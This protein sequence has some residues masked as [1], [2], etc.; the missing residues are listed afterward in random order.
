[1]YASGPSASFEYSR[2]HKPSVKL[3]YSWYGYSSW[4]KGKVSDLFSWPI[5]HCATAQVIA[6]VD[7]TLLTFPYVEHFKWECRTAQ[8]CWLRALLTASHPCAAPGGFAWAP[9]PWLVRR[10]KCFVFSKI[11]W[12]MYNS[13]AYPP[14]PSDLLTDLLLCSMPMSSRFCLLWDLLGMP[15]SQ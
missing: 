8:S 9:V 14:S 15:E 3:E 6:A 5:H 7:V 12:C 4:S 13:V 10:G 2:V 1:M 11:A